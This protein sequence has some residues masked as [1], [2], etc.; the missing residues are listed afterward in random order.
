MQ[1][2]HF[3]LKAKKMSTAIEKEKKWSMEDRLKQK[4]IR[5]RERKKEKKE[6]E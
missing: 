3:I 4:F 5:K 6:L 1:N 2:D